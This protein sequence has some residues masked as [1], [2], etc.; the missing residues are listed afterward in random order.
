[1]RTEALMI[2]IF[3]EMLRDKR[4]LALMFIAPLFIMTLIFFLFQSNTTTKVDLAVHGVQTSLTKAMDTKH[5]R[6]HHVGTEKPTRIIKQHD[7]A[8]VLTQHGNQLTLTLANTDQGQSTLLK[9]TLQAATV[10]LR[11]KAAATSLKTQA[12]ALNK[13]ADALQQAT[14]GAV[15]V[16]IPQQPKQTNYR[17]TTHYRYGSAESTYFDTLLPILIGFIVFFFVFLISGIALLRERTTGTLYRL[18]VTPIRRGEIISGYLLGYGIFAV[19]QTVLIV[20]YALVVF[21]I[22]ILGSI[23]AIFLINLLL[24]LTALAL[25]L[26]ISTFANSEFQMLQFIPIIV[27]PQIF[28]TGLIPVN[29]MLGWLQPIAH[30]MPLYYGANALTGIITKGQSLAVL[31][32]DVIALVGF[33]LLFLGLNLLTMRK[34][35]QV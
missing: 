28:F 15:Q 30:L 13:L 2:R 7:Y 6:L 17:M 12:I 21:K 9:Q 34:Y 29:Q 35:R 18:L 27:I 20:G 24:A 8:G 33:F 19:I 4:T 23:P 25:G 14:H 26:L 1:M 31:Y 5:L 22:Q 16:P 32:P 10:K 3:K 11:L